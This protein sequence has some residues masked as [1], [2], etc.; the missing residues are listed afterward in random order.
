V[1]DTARAWVE[2]LDESNVDEVVMLRLER[3]DGVSAERFE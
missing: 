3:F 1:I 2:E